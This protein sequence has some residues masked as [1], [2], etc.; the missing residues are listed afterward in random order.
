[1]LFDLDCKKIQD[2]IHALKRDLR[3]LEPIIPRTLGCIF[4]ADVCNPM[5]MKMVALR[6]ARVFP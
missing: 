5:P 4:A 1:M 6:R 2:K 3:S